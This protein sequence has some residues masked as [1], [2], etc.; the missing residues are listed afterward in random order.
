MALINFNSKFYDIN[1]G[2]EPT[3]ERL[4]NI[5][6]K[7]FQAKKF[8]RFCHNFECREKYHEISTTDITYAIGE[9]SVNGGQ[10]FG[11]A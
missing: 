4:C 10:G 11:S 2:K 3:T 9:S 6:K 8:D 5:C 7:P 1:Y